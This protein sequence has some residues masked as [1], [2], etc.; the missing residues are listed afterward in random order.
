MVSTNNCLDCATSFQSNFLACEESTFQTLSAFELARFARKIAVW[1]T[2]FCHAC[3]MPV[4]LLWN[5][6]EIVLLYLDYLIV[7]LLRLCSCW[8]V[9]CCGCWCRCWGQISF[10]AVHLHGRVRL[11]HIDCHLLHYLLIQIS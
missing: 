8:S 10:S 7:G 4:R 9:V 5:L 6:I 2:Y 11:S 1:C 3:V